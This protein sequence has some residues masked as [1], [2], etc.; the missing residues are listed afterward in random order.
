MKISIGLFFYTTEIELVS[1]RQTIPFTDLRGIL[2]IYSIGTIFCEV[3][4][5]K[6]TI[7]AN[8]L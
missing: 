6:L 8:L 5:V 1:G 3:L 7:T 2:V 4:V